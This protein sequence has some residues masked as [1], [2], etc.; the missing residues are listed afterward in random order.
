MGENPPPRARTAPSSAPQPPTPG[1]RELRA[2]TWRLRE[3][4]RSE[5]EQKGK[6]GGRGGGAKGGGGE[7]AGG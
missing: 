1:A 6:E 7:E 3:D 5:G 4:G 2:G